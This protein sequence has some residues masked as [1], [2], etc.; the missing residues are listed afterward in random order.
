MIWHVWV[1]FM[2]IC[3]S[4]RFKSS[5]YY[6]DQFG[7]DRIWVYY[8]RVCKSMFT[9]TLKNGKGQKV[10]RN[11]TNH[12]GPVLVNFPSPK[13]NKMSSFLWSAEVVGMSMTPINHYS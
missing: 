12:K 13:K 4:N 11:L 3:L 7:S 9:L 8:V 10:L 5:G 6:L 1:I 2:E